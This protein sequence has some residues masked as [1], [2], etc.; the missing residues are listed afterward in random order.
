MCD[1]IA[2]WETA[3]VRLTPQQ[4]QDLNDELTVLTKQQ[5]DARLME[6]FVGMTKGE[7]EA[8]ELRQERISRIHII[9]SDHDAKR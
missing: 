2:H 7:T 1:L 3:M 6:V 4:L 9:L 8:F 5:S